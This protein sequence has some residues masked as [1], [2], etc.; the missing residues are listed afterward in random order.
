[1]AGKYQ[2]QKIGDGLPRIIGVATMFAVA[3]LANL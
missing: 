3:I 1:M 2:L